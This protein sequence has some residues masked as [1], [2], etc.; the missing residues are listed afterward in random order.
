[1]APP[2]LAL[3]AAVAKN[4]VIGADNTLPW[5]LPADLQRFKALTLGHSVV[6]GRRTWQ[7]LPRALPGRQ[8]IVVTRSRD[9]T[10]PGADVAHS[11]DDALRLARMPLPVFCIGGADLFSEAMARADVLYMTEIDRDFAGD[12]HF[13]AFD[14]TRWR[15][16]AREA[17]RSDQGFDYAFV[18]YERTSP[19][20]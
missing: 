6:M 13:P 2:A 1:M 14:R 4:G 16:T 19:K 18:T 7:S 15:E 10:A 5:R 8:N 20:E 17:A 12:V 11:F 3:I 9:F